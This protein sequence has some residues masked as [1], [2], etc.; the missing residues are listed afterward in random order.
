MRNRDQRM[1][2]CLATGFAVTVAEEKLWDPLSDETKKSL[3]DWLGG[4]NDK[5]MLNTNWL[6]FRV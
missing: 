5:E 1:V 4:M 2:E 6:W 3:E